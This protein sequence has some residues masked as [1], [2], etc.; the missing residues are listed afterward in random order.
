MVR[1]HRPELEVVYRAAERWVAEALRGDGSL[2]TP[3]EAIWTE[4]LL[5]EL[6]ERF[7]RSPDET[8]D[9]FQVKLERQL[10]GASPQT[11]Q[12]MGEVLYVHLLVA[13]PTS[14]KGET[15][16]RLINQVLS[17]AA[18]VTAAIPSELDAALDQGFAAT[19]TAFNTYRPFQLALIIEFARAWKQQERKEQ[20]KLLEEPWAFREFLYDVAL[21]R[22]AHSQREALLHLVH[23]AT[24]ERCVSRDAKARIA[25]TFSEL[26]SDPTQDVDRQLAEVRHKLAEEHGA[27]LDFWDPDIRRQWQP[28]TSL[29]G[30]FIHWASRFYDSAEFDSLERD[31]RHEI[32]ERLT[33]TRDALLAGTEWLAPLKKAF[34]PPNNLMSYH[35][36]RRLLDW[37]AAELDAA[38]LALQ[39][40]WQPERTAV[41]RVRDF[42]GQI[43]EDV[44]SGRG[45]RTTLASFLMMAVDAAQYPIYQ[46]RPFNKAMDL[47]QYERPP[48]DSDEAEVYEHALA[49]LDRLASEA[50]SRGLELRDRLDA[51]SV[52]WLVVRWP[53]DQVDLPANERRALGRYR[54]S[55]LAEEGDEAAEEE[56]STISALT[57]ETLAER[58]LIDVAWLERIRWLL[59]DK[60]QVIFYGPPGTG[61]TYVAQELAAALTRDQNRVKLV[62]FHPSYA[63]EDF[64]EGYRPTELKGGSP[65]FKLRHG[66]LRKLAETAIATPE[67]TF[68]LV[69]DEINRGNVAK[70]FGELYF[71]LEYRKRNVI[72]QYSDEEFALPENL[73]IIGT[74]NTADRTIALLDAALRRRFHF[75]PFL[76]SQPPID[77][78]LRRW[79][80][81]HR[82]GLEWVADMIDQANKKLD[83]R[84]LAIGP[85]HFLKDHLDEESVELI[86]SHSIE[87]YVQ[88]H[89][90]SEPE[91]WKEFTYESV[92]RS[93]M[94]QVASDREDVDAASATD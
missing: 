63:Y 48:V 13:S 1:S 6:N 94:S 32:V 73:W 66:P 58:L 3:G 47:T 43:P 64:V 31:Y 35:T 91:R 78:L 28:D 71:L 68:V 41:Q 19:G 26:V 84:D 44:V 90:F 51:Q 21:P 54:G 72:L 20:E 22:G 52:L 24:F 88:E 83:D 27:Q 81:E 12:L 9:A 49:F 2:F 14:S 29:W 33:Q 56:A 15:K 37:C 17:W 16:R 7:V 60:R 39:A 82:P 53:I 79:L 46:T 57:L 80:R 89:F 74:M 11:V 67:E 23:P 38:R 42:L 76:P 70:V 45:S 85:S 30:Q 86:W 55:E 69:I 75:V 62:Q 40:M 10:D 5:D 77:G 59:E 4:A 18:P 92:R 93:V 34:G 87:P 36:Y 8:S 25:K 65:G 50:S 61:K